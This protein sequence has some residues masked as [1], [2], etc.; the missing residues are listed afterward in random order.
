MVC[1]LLSLVIIEGFIL[2]H[3]GSEHILTPSITAG[4]DTASHYYTLDYLFHELLPKGRISGWTPGNYA[5][6]PILQFYFPLAFLIMCGLGLLM[7]LAISFKI[8]TLSGVF[9]LPIGVYAFFRFLRA[10]FPIPVMGAA[11]IMPFLFNEANSVWGGNVL[12]TLAGEFSYSLSLALSFILLGSL[13]RG[14]LDNRGVLLNA[15]LVFLVGFSHG[16]TLLFA[17]A[18]SGYLL[19]TPFGFLRRLVYLIKVYALGFLLMAFWLVPLL[20]HSPYTIAFHPVW[21]IHSVTQI[22][23]PVLIPVFVLAGLGFAWIAIGRRIGAHLQARK[24]GQA[25]WRL[26]AGGQR[27]YESDDG[28]DERQGIGEASHVLGFLCFGMAVAA[29]MFAAAPRIGVVDIRY[30]PYAQLMVCLIGALGLGHVGAMLSSRRFIEPVMLIAV[31]AVLCW[32]HAHVDKA[33]QWSEWNYEGFENKAAWPL[34]SGINDALSGSF[35]DP[36]V[37]VEHAAKHNIF[38]SVRAFES[39]PLFSGRATMEGL[40]LQASLNSPFVFYL[41]SEISKQKSAPFYLYATTEMDFA[42]AKRRL[43]MFNVRELV[44]T[45]RRARD[46]IG[47]TPGYRLVKRYGEYEIW[48]LAAQDDAYVTPLAFEPVPYV[49]SDW[50]MDT[51]SWFQRDDLIDVHLV[52]AQGGANES[53]QLGPTAT[54]LDEIRRIPVDGDACWVKESIASEEIIMETNCI[55]RPLLIKM[56][57]HPNWRVEGADGVHL[58]SPAFMLVYPKEQKVRLYYGSGL[59]ERAGLVLTGVGI[60]ACLLLIP[61]SWGKGGTDVSKA[62]PGAEQPSSRQCRRPGRPS[63]GVRHRLITGACLIVAAVIGGASYHIYRNEPARVFNRSIDMRDGGLFDEAREG[64]SRVMEQIPLSSLAHESA[65]YLA[66]TYYIEGDYPAAIAAFETLIN[67]YPNGK[68]NPEALYHIG[69]CLPHTGAAENGMARL[70]QLVLKHPGSIWAGY[71]RERIQE[72][73]LE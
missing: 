31:V 2:Y 26:I 70:K 42:R 22:I 40:Y 37:A 10:S 12:S 11:L 57:Y 29:V 16:Y 50:K 45:S 63:P 66:S 73:V 43:E 51:Y 1:D 13:Y 64:F 4:G 5:G 67:R 3:V 36:R 18:A 53:R 35:A 49:T 23:P 47:K 39:L 54:S 33:G 61:L 60:F 27:A 65:Y 48:K 56:S 32:T 21:R 30:V 72:Q 25:A 17:G 71:A 34:F 28:E 19:I 58:A 52:S 46:A 55:D 24:P 15:I 59:P 8:V 62:A 7:P 14:C 44:I 6:F 38:G 69:I 68:R 41:Q 20:F 9:L